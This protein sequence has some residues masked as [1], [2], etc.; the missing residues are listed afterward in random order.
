[1]GE[2]ERVAAVVDTC[3]WEAMLDS[4]PWK[5]DLESHKS[6]LDAMSW[7]LALKGNRSE[8]DDLRRLVKASQSCNEMSSAE[9]GGAPM[10]QVLVL[11]RD[12]QEMMRFEFAARLA[13]VEMKLRDSGKMSVQPRAEADELANRLET[14]KAHLRTEIGKR[15]PSSSAVPSPTGSGFPVE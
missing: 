13:E 4:R 7:E 10:A 2:L 6:I 1:M 3:P 8:L 14:I 5:A 9:D 11:I 15:S 12:A